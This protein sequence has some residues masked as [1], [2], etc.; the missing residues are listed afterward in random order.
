MDAINFMNPS[1]VMK[2]YDIVKMS[3][4]ASLETCDTFLF[5][6]YHY[7]E[8]RK[9]LNALFIQQISSSFP[10]SVLLLEGFES[11][12][13]IE[14]CPLPYR[15]I[16]DIARFGWDMNEYVRFN[17]AP[18]IVALAA[19]NIGTYLTTDFGLE[20]DR[21]FNWEYALQIQLDSSGID[22]LPKEYIQEIHRVALL[23]VQHEKKTGLSTLQSQMS[24]YLIGPFIDKIFLRKTFLDH[25]FEETSLRLAKFI[26]LRNNFMVS[27]LKGIHETLPP[28]RKC[29][30][31]AGVEHL[32]PTLLETSY[33]PLF[34]LEALYDYMKITPHHIAILRPTDPPPLTCDGVRPDIRTFESGMENFD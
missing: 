21:P 18:L 32:A 19:K 8:R 30:L 7:D 6:E 34:S 16:P 3:D 10:E 31:V 24:E 4:G 33:G 22:G 5:C 27:S 20:L 9:R 23:I 14:K 12:V 15:E 13:S 29:V 25:F 26:P 1:E 17:E 11:L 28:G 2:Y